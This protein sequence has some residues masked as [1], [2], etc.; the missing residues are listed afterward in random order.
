MKTTMAVA[1]ALALL[2]QGCAAKQPFTAE[3]FRQAVPGA[4]MAKKETVEVNRP[5]RAVAETFRKRGPECLRVTVRTTSS[6]PGTSYQVVVADYAPT[7]VVTSERAELH[8]QEKHK[9]GVMKVAQEPENGHY[10]VVADAYPVDKNKTRLELFGPTG[11]P[12]ALVIRTL[13][14]WASGESTGCPDFAK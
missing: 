14:S 13:K 12:G 10:L 6:Q 11:G 9:Q 3:E 1:G 5:F 8:L 7:V 4:F 2:L